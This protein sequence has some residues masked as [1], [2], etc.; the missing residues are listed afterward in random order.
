MHHQQRMKQIIGRF[1]YSKFHNCL[2]INICICTIC[3]RNVLTISAINGNS[4]TLNTSSIV[5]GVKTANASGIYETDQIVQSA[6][7]RCQVKLKNKCRLDPLSFLSN[8]QIITTVL[9]KV[10]YP[11][12]LL[13]LINGLPVINCPA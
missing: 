10:R 12:N 3:L 9:P 6:E 2:L 11:C 7:K 4:L 5:F 13:C 8:T 1:L